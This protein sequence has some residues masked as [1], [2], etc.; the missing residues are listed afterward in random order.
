MRAA[1]L[2]ALLWTASSAP[3][4]TCLVCGEIRSIRELSAGTKQPPQSTVSPSGTQSDLYAG[5]VVGTV[6]QFHYGGA[7]T[8]GTGG[9]GEGWSFGA[10]GTPEMQTRLGATSYEVTVAMDSGERRTLQRRDGNRFHVGQR[11][12]VRQGELEPM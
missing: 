12:A 3:A 1:L 9:R 6:A 5:P 8:T 11:V 4:Q 10:A 7:R 2:A